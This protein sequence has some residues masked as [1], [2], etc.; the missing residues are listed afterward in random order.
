MRI[1]IFP[2]YADGG[3]LSTASARIRAAWVAKYWP[4]ADLYSGVQ[5]IPD[6]DAYVFQKVY[7]R[8]YWRAM[9]HT[10]RERG[11]LLAIDLCDP[12]W[13]QGGQVALREALPL[14]DFAVASTEPIRER[15]GRTVPAYVIP[16]R[17]D[18]ECHRERKVHEPTDTPSAV[19]FGYAANQEAID[20][21][22][23]VLK[24]HGVN[25]TV[26]SDR[27][28]RRC[29]LPYVPWTL[30]GA[31]AEIVRHDLVINPPGQDPRWRYKSNNK[32]LTGWALGMP[33]A[34]DEAELVR[35]LDWRERREEGERRWNEVREWWD[36]RLSVQQ[37]QSLMAQYSQGGAECCSSSMTSS[38]AATA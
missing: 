22:L 19:W 9:L 18:L 36:V 34:H 14:F 24:Q 35:F 20:A 10:L 15:L 30:E 4:E 2:A 37:W 8:D 1:L 23:P 17:L 11:K 21:F 7:Y 28:Y 38:C 33:V 3:S 31:N 26:L 16:D 29:E 12:V 13:M 32:T 5:R 6:Y 25:L 27:A